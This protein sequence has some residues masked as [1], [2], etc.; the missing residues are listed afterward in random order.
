[1]TMFADETRGAVI[2]GP[3][4]YRLSRRLSS[5]HRTLGVVG[6]NPSTADDS[7]DDHTVRKLIGYAKRWGFDFIDLCNIFAW[8][9]TDPSALPH[10]TDPVGPENSL[11]L[12]DM[13][14]R[15]DIVLVMTGD[16]G[17]NAGREVAWRTIANLNVG[18]ALHALRVSAKTGFP[19]HC[20]Y[21]R[22]DASPFVWRE[23]A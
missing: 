1:M 4:R 13:K 19:W 17:W 9:A 15:A 16:P 18:T 11:H 5:G 3:Y 2:S 23:A 20:L 10:V 7:V 21:L 12:H 8:R 14:K 22:N 6:L